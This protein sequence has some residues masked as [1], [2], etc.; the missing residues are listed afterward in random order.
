MPKLRGKP[1]PFHKDLNGKERVNKS[2]ARKLWSWGLPVWADAGYGAK[3]IARPGGIPAQEN[4]V[5]AFRAACASAEPCCS[6]ESR[7]KKAVFLSP[8]GPMCLHFEF[9]DG[10]NPFV[11]YGRPIELL[12]EL[13]AW[14]RGGYK[15][16]TTVSDEPTIA[17]YRLGAAG[18]RTAPLFP[19]GSGM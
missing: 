15:I 4:T 11:K 13:N 14:H 3:L 16:R 7:W 2:M 1:L 9:D 6:D 10:S 17:A 18:D 19:A 12:Y 5:E 8:Y